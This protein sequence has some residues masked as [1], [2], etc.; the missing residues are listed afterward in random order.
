MSSDRKTGRTKKDLQEAPAAKLQYTDMEG[1][2]LA[3][4][5]DLARIG[6]QQRKRGEIT[7]WEG[8]AKL[9]KTQFDKQF[10]STTWNCIVGTN[11][12]SFVSQTKGTMAYFFVAEMGVMLWKHA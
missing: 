3:E 6:Y 7:N 8:V 4:A 5:Y 10:K 11:F 1:K 12:G 9:V 2:M